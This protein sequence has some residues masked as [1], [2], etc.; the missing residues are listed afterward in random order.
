M[1]SRLSVR[2]APCSRYRSRSRRGNSYR[3]DGNS[4]AGRSSSQERIS[5]TFHLGR[6]KVLF[7]RQQHPDMAV[8]IAHAGGVGAIEH[9]GGWLNLLGA[10]L[11]RAPHECRVV[12]QEEV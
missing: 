7:P 2:V 4:A 8:G 3:W 12:I 9:V 6:S 10:C 1:L 5:A 11:D